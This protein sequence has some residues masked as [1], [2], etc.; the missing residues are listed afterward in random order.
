M[1]PFFVLYL[2][3]FF[4]L[5]LLKNFSLAS[6]RNESISDEWKKV[7]TLNHSPSGTAVAVVFKPVDD[8]G[9]IPHTLSRG[10]LGG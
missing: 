2:F 4:R 7:M 3:C 6:P 10:S 1:S 5:L 8:R 9:R